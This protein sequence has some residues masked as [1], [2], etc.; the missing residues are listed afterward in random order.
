MFA[1]LIASGNLSEVQ[2]LRPA[3]AI[4]PPSL[5]RPSI[6][7][8]NGLSKNTCKKPQEYSFVRDTQVQSIKPK[9]LGDGKAKSI[10]YHAVIYEK[11]C[12]YVSP[13]YIL[14]ALNDYFA[15]C[16]LRVSHE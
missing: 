10:R 13:L 11:H 4:S 15:K 6:F 14:C 9:K 3:A 7:A 1:T 8:H 16:S 5:P 2:E 12:G